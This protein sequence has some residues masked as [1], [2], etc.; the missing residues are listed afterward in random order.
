[1]SG[2]VLPP[3]VDVVEARPLSDYRIA[4]LFEDGKRG[5]YDASPLIGAGCFIL[6]KILWFSTPCALNTVRSYGRVGLTS[7]QR[8]FTKTASPFNAVSI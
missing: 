1:M 8:N 6:L 5:I 7:L 3:I 4:L 2:S